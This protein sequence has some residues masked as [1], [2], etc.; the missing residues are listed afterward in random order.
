MLNLGK[1][2]VRPFI[3][4]K[5][6]VYFNEPSDVDTMFSYNSGVGIRIKKT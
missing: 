1:D 2:A 4:E 5:P 6:D 3:T